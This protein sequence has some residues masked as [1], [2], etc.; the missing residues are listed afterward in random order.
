M[1]SPVVSVVIPAYGHA[2]LIGRT[3]RSVLGQVDPPE[4]EIVVVDDGS[5]DDTA[6]AVKPFADRIVYHRQANAGQAAA[7][8]KGI[9]LARGEFVQLLDD[10]D[11]LA[12]GKIRRH[13]DLLREQP[14]AVLVYGEDDHIGPDDRSI[15]MVPRP[16]YP[17]P[18]GD[19]HRDFLVGCF[20][21]T[22]GQTL[23]RRSALNAVG[24]FD[25]TIWGSD[26]WELYIR[27]SKLGP[28]IH[29][30]LVS[31]HYRVHPG[32]SSGNVLRHVKAHQ[33]AFAKHPVDDP[34]LVQ[35]RRQSAIDYFLPNLMRLSHR[36]RLDGDLATSLDAQTMAARLQPSIRW[37]REWWQPYLLNRLG[38]APRQVREDPQAD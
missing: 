32:N 2:T 22:P 35:R 34:E 13:V 36:A 30:P 29:D 15:E 23:I 5:P 21:A 12:S 17:R 33:L 18:S 16:N 19:C 38:R 4:L 28:F 11:L 25:T 37:R 24:P 20:I 8:N 3:I 26:D 10:D 9:E 14:E 27:L 1:N 7:R 31:L 6:E